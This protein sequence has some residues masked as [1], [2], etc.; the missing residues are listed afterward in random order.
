MKSY[1]EIYCRNCRKV[2]GRYNR[3]FYTEDRIGDLLKTSH[4]RHVR[5]GHQVEIR[6]VKKACG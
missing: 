6:M 5:G 3:R 2:I 1:C 4:A